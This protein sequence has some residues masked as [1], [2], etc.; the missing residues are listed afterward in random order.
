M[1][2][3]KTIILVLILITISI[4]LVY[5]SYPHSKSVPPTNNL[6]STIDSP[7]INNN[8]LSDGQQC[9]VYDHEATKDEPYTTH[10]FINIT[11]SGKKIQ[12]IKDGTQKGPDM[13]NGYTGT[14][15]GKVNDNI[16]DVLFSYTI[17]GSKNQGKELY[18]VRED[19]LG[20]EKLRYPLVEKNGIL[21]PDITKEFKTLL[22][23]RVGCEASN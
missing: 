23:S 8:W 1:K 20:I 5:L 17:E 16:I 18:S 9:Y 4:F 13:T 12:G 3:S 7:I 11:V 19:Q 6:A 14:L 22:Y 15:T 2:N 21:V 10:E